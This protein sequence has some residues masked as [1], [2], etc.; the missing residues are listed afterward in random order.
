M[1]DKPTL[2]ADVAELRNVL[3]AMD[4]WESTDGDL[5]RAQDRERFVA[6]LDDDAAYELDGL[7]LAGLARLVRAEQA[8]AAPVRPLVEDRRTPVPDL[9]SWM[10]QRRP[11]VAA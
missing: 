4:D 5:T 7:A 11:R 2:L 3:R 6:G 9:N 8:A 10:R 1:T